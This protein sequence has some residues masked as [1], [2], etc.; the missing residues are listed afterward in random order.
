MG[1]TNLSRD[2]LDYHADMSEYREA[3]LRLFRDLLAPDGAA[4][5]NT[6]D[7]E[8]LP[9]L[10][11]ALD[12]GVHLLT[13]GSEGAFFEISSVETDGFGQ[14]VKARL[15]GEPVAFHL[16]LDR[17]LPGRQRGDGGGAGHPDRRR[18]GKRPST[19]STACAAPGAGWNWPDGATARPSSSTIRTSRSRSRARS[20][21]CG[22]SP[23][24]ASSSCSAAAAT[25]I[26]ASARSWARS[27]IAPRRRR[28]CHRRQSAHR[29]PGRHSRRNPGRTA[30]GAREIGDRAEA[31]RVA[32]KALG[33]GDVLLVAGKGHEDYQIVGTQ[34]RHFSDH[35]E[36][37]RGPCRPDRPGRVNHGVNPRLAIR[38]PPVI[39]HRATRGPD[40][41]G[42]IIARGARRD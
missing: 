17:A 30:P 16:P 11:A 3:K 36:V 31:I 8:H 42:R 24:D 39:K 18:S 13:V 15:V 1:F 35:E 2:H 33:D 6:D 7:P 27:P 28:H 21:R 22:P 25:V 38:G 23:A 40:R 32:V 29:G 9:F 37:A 26:A 41:S 4:V 12:R 14:K 19:R 5:V 20:R 10:F 34:K